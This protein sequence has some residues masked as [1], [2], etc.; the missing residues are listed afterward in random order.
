M[1]QQRVAWPDGNECWSGPTKRPSLWWCGGRARLKTSFM[2][3]MA[4]MS[5]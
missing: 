2:T 5:T 3:M 1:H 4:T